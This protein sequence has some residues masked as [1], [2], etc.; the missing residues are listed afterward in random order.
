MAA[1]YRIVT[2]LLINNG[3]TPFT[4]NKLD[5][6]A[7]LIVEGATQE[8]IIVVDQLDETQRGEQGFSHSGM[9]P[10]VAKIYAIAMGGTTDLKPIEERYR[11]LRTVVPEVYH[12]F[13]DVFDTDLCT[14]R[15]P[16]SRP[17]YDF[18]I[19]LIPGAKLPPP[20]KPYHL[21]QEETHILK[22]W[23]DGMLSAGLIRKCTTK[24]PT[25]TPVFFVGK[26]DRNKRPCIDYRKL[27]DV[28]IKNAY[29]IPRIDQ[30]MDQ[31]KGSSIFSKFNLKLGYNQIR[32]KEG[33]EFMAAFVTPWGAFEPLV[34]GFGQAGAPPFFQKFMNDHVYQRPELV[35]HVVRYL[36]DTTTHN[37]SV[38]EHIQTNKTLFQRCQD[39]GIFLNLKKCEFHKE[40]VEFLG[41]ELSKDGF[42]MEKAKVNTI[43]KWQPPRNVKGV[44][45]FIGFCNFY[46]RFIKNF[47]EIARPLHDLTRLGQ[48]WIWS[49]KEQAAFQL[50]KDIIST[51][52]VLI[53][54][55]LERQFRLETDALA[56]A[57]RAVLSQLAEKDNR[58][59]PVGFFLKSM[60]NAERNYRISDR[61]ALAV[62]KAL[63]HW[64]HWLEGTT[65]PVEIIT[66]HRNLEYFTKPKI[67]NHRQLRWMDQ[68]THY[69]YQIKYRPGNQNGAA[70]ALSQR[71]ELSP[72]D[73]PEDAPQT[74]IP[75]ERIVATLMAHTILSDSEIQDAIVQAT[76]SLTLPSDIVRVDGVPYHNEQIFV[77][78]NK[79]IKRN[80]MALYHDS[81]LAGHLGQSGTI[82]LIQ[83]RYWWPKMGMEIWD[84]IGSCNVCAQHKHTNQ[85]PTGT[86]Q[87]LLVLEGP[88]QWTQSDHVTGLPKSRGHDAIYVVMDRLTKMAHFIPTSTWAT[89]E[90]LAQL[91]LN[92][93]WKLHGVPKVHN[94]DRG[95]LFTAEYKKRFFK[96]LGINQRFSTPY[97]PQTQGQVENLN[98][99]METY[100]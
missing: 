85:R 81:P 63:Q 57:Y 90:D 4:V 16:P 10:E 56:F 7:Q 78:D 99:W 70:D 98:K 91:H 80:I 43:T 82:D 32:I 26:K 35:H 83:R 53:H 62:V 75:P 64:R 45:A 23:I 38:A 52:P 33:H 36:D 58:H 100:I 37:T 60:N 47:A 40:R 18:D 50:L 65:L 92:H 34:V 48:R 72:T 21:S 29:P 3:Q 5:C 93:V 95:P 94:M 17:D 68:L 87:V 71:P 54:P 44:R 61:E 66:D 41:V 76:L 88:W 19:N 8:E 74:M 49:E 89:A 55:N 27:N 79:E 6:I 39:I 51:A 11:Y 96:G 84:Y 28:T 42:E 77:P 69:N 97:H 9:T 30:I 20:A 67:L 46:R 15:L 24:L 31:V 25:A 14:S 2:V 12:D 1:M 73:P 86:L 13:L 22:D 59:H